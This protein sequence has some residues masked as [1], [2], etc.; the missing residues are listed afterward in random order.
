[1]PARSTS[2]I[3]V[4]LNDGAGLR[5]VKDGEVSNV[6]HASHVSNT[7]GEFADQHEGFAS[8]RFLAT[9]AELY[10]LCMVNTF[11]KS[12]RTYFG[13]GG[14]LGSTIDFIVVP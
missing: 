6:V 1:M 2:V 9:V 5:R 4:D 3:F 13:A 7:V 11:F 12:N 10:S 8:S 14:H